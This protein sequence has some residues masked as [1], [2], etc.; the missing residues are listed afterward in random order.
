MITAERDPRTLPKAPD[1]EW[2]H[3]AAERIDSACAAADALNEELL[4]A[5]RAAGAA[6]RGGDG[7]QGE[8]A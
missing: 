4:A 5:R 8:A 2:W 7:E 3:R 6:G 1:A